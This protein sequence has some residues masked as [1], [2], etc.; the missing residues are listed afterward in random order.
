MSRES[1]ETMVNVRIYKASLA[2]EA[3]AFRIVAEY[4]QAVG[5]E[6]RD[7]EESFRNSYF[8]DGGGLW[9]AQAPLGPE[10]E[11]VGCIAMR[12]LPRMERAAEVKR[13]YV[14]PEWRGRGIADALLDELERYAMEC[15]IGTLY[16]DS[17]DDLQAALRFYRRRGY[18]SCARYNDNPQATVFMRKQLTAMG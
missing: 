17:K 14:R 18:Q 4:N 6:V 12:A 9:L 13:L 16:L 11:A 8:R 1:D 7:S 5:V 15:G 2:E 3:E 10:Q